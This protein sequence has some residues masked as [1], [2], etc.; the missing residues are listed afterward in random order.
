MTARVEVAPGMFTWARERAG[1]ALEDL[2]GRFGRLPEWEAGE[3]NP[4]M[5]QL[6]DFAS[7]TH[8]PVGYFFL[9][10]P[11]EE[12]LP[13]ADYRP[14]PEG[15][16]PRLSP[17]LLDV[18]YL[19]QQR[20]EWY[21]DFAISMGEEPVEFV[22]SATKASDVVETAAAMRGLVHFDLDKRADI[23]TW[24]DALR[25]LRRQIEDAGVLVMISGIVGSNT[26]R[27]L[28]VSEFRGFS[29][30]DPIAPLIFVNGTDTKVAQI[31]TIAHELGHI[32][33][34]ESGV[35]NPQ[36]DRTVDLAN[37]RWCNAFAAE[38]LVPLAVLADTGST[39]G[40]LC[41]ALLAH[42][43]ERFARA[44]ATSTLEGHT[45]Y[46]DAFR[47]LGFR[48]QATFDRL[49]GRLDLQA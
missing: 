49:V 19:C 13:I 24:A 48:K 40:S 34:G 20:Q 31:F 43:S 36:M 28:Q 45:L 44:V 18:L 11:P 41:D 16:S 1:L 39:G 25:T 3:V 12:P 14:L 35:S 9:D 5:R 21:R 47:M 32:L 30:S 22:G 2:E 10:E 46:R 17:D 23:P 33:L 8:A 27:P 42:V 29:L 26:R 38:F 15:Q 7:A 37:E 4:T 6:Q